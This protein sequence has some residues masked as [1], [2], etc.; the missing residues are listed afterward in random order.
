M[1]DRHIGCQTHELEMDEQ[2]LDI[3]GHEPI[4]WSRALQQLEAQAGEGGAAGLVG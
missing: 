3:Y 1:F 4:P 2:N